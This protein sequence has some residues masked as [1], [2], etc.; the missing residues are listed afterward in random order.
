MS[1]ASLTSTGP[2][3]GKELG[4]VYRE[5]KLRLNPIL[6]K[7]SRKKHLGKRA[8]QLTKEFQVQIP[9]HPTWMP[10]KLR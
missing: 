1:T 6:K 10:R 9:A 8:L 3:L 5:K 2:R 4:E 7:L